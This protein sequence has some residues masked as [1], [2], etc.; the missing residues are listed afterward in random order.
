[1]VV[2]EVPRACECLWAALKRTPYRQVNTRI[3]TPLSKIKV[4]TGDKNTNIV[5]TSFS[6]VFPAK[7]LEHKERKENME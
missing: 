6:A 1:M 7:I 5:E 4:A 3:V 2:F